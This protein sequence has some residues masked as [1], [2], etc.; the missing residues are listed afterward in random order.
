MAGSPASFVW[1]ELLTPDPDA[2][3]RFYA[4]VVGWSVDDA[5]R[6]DMDYR[7]L[8]APD[9]D[10][11]AGV[12]EKCLPGGPVWLGYV[13]VEDVDA[14]VEAVRDRGGEVRVP[15]E[16]LP[17]VGRISMVA[18]AQGAS[19]Y[20]M[21]GT[22]DAPSRAFA[23]GDEAT[24]GHAVWNELTAAD[25]EAAI[26]FYAGAFGWRQEGSM[27]MGGSSEYRFIHSGPT[28]LGAVMSRGPEGRDG[29]LF[30]FLVA[31]LG[32]ATERLRARGGGVVQGPDEI[33]GGGFSLVAVDPQGARFGLV[34]AGEA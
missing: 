4:D 18:D 6:D 32:A 2:A 22:S 3:Q 19:L 7:L 27:P 14:A 30:Y 21:R 17:G 29:W 9:G 28:C 15:A 26:D 8:A 33:P 24:P 11:I 10:P 23:Q 13:G 5:G 1:Y 12:M 16:N 25:P 34:G 31:D 20:V